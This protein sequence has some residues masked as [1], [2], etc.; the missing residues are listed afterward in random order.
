MVLYIIEVK[1]NYKKIIIRFFQ[2]WTAVA[3]LENF[4]DH[5]VSIKTKSENFCE[6]LYMAS[7]LVKFLRIIK[8]RSDWTDTTKVQESKQ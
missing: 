5:S 3:C 4:F 1:I 7:N 2:L 8:G 6:N